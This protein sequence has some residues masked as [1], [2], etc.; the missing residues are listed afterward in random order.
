MFSNKEFLKFI[1][2]SRRKALD[3]VVASVI[4]TQ[5]ST[6]AKAGNMLLVNSIG[7]FIG[8]LGS[9]FLH[10]KILEASKDIFNS[11]ESYIFES[12]PQD[13][14]SGHGHSKYFLQPFFLSENYGVVG[15]A[16]ENIGKTLV[17]STKDNSYKILDEKCDTKLENDEFYQ[18]IES[19]YNLLIFGSGA[20]VKSLI[21][22][23]NLMAWKTTVIDL[24]I[25]EYVN[26]ADELIELEKVED[27]L[28]MDLSSYNA[29]V[30][31]SHSPKTDDIYLKALLNSN[32]EYI[33]MM[34]NKKNMKRKIE[35]FKLENDKRFF[36]PVG[37]D[38]GGN[39]H[40]AIAL[41]ICSQIEAKKNGKI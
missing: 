20:H 35:Q 26:E 32:A 29:S 30:I 14:S 2:D 18:T 34:G 7:E 39:T 15:L 23:A 5:G 31:L 41:S 40:Q 11:K 28:T 3:I 6:Y 13:E 19:P 22:M 27:I 38:I 1:E 17:R 16:K 21:S 12:I 37:F 8:V 25:K 10:N 9:P 24:K 4:Q 36:A 33:G